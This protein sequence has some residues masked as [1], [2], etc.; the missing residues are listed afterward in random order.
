M[1][2]TSGS[3][4]GRAQCAVGVHSAASP[5]G[6]CEQTER[7]TRDWLFISLPQQK[8]AWEDLLPLVSVP[9][10]DIRHSLV[11]PVYFSPNFV[12]RIKWAQYNIF[13]KNRVF[14]DVAA[15]IASVSSSLFTLF[16]LSLSQLSLHH[17]LF[18][19]LFIFIPAS[20]YSRLLSL[21]PAIPLAPPSP[22]FGHNAS[23]CGIFYYAAALPR[24]IPSNWGG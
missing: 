10:F 22:Q 15:R 5:M 11:L 2:Q 20:L 18:R 16:F 24:W 9:R 1:I 4:F 8:K 23:F 6:R 19:S 7:L 13:T 17:F 14:I 12:V 3:E 21:T